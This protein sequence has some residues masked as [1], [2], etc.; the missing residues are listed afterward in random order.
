MRVEAIGQDSQSGFVHIGK[1]LPKVLKEV[2]RRVELR[3]RLEAEHGG[4]IN[5]QEFIEVAEHD[6]GC[7]L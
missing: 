7:R 4:Q 6:E 1:L 5:D 2:A 3:Q